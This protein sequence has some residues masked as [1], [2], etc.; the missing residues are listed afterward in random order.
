[1]EEAV[2]FPPTKSQ[3]VRAS[4]N[5]ENDHCLNLLC[6]RGWN[7]GGYVPQWVEI[8]LGDS[9]RVSGVRL[10]VN[11]LPDGETRNIVRGGLTENPTEILVDLTAPT[12]TNQVLNLSFPGNPLVRFL[13]IETV[14]SPSWVA[15]HRIE[16]VV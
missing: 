11:M 3:Y 9:V 12:V 5:W 4:G 7:S 16:V 14:L 1:M 15:W 10:T 2:I 13:R 6:G 8:D